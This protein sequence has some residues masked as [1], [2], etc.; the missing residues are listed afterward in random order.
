MNVKIFCGFSGGADSTA[1]L[2]LLHKL[3][4][5]ENIQLTAVHFDHGLRG[6]E[7]TS[8]AL[9]CNEF[10][11]KR[12]IK[13][14]LVSLD[15]PNN[16]KKG[17]GDEEASRRL[18]IQAWTKITDANSIIALGHNANDRIENLFL[19]LLRGSNSSG[20]TS[21]RKTS[22]IGKLLFFRPLLTIPRAKI[23]NFLVSE[24]IREWRHDSSNSKSSYRRNFI[25]NVLVSEL[26]RKIPSAE[27][28]IL[29]SVCAVENDAQYI[30]HQ[31]D[32]EYAKFANRG[33]IPLEYLQNS[34]PAILIRIL[35]LWVKNESG[36]DFIPNAAFLNRL[37]TEIAKFA[38]KGKKINSKSLTIPV[39]E[40]IKFLFNKK[41][42]FIHQKDIPDN[43][44]N[45]KSD[46]SW[47]CKKQNKIIWGKFTFR[48]SLVPKPRLQ[49]M[50]TKS[51]NYTVFYDAEN[52][53]PILKIRGWNNDDKIIPFGMSNQVKVKK[54]LENAKIPAPERKNIPVITIPSNDQIIWIPG[55][56]RANFAN[57]ASKTRGVIVLKLCL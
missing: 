11:K 16:R 8:D 19:R 28:A 42:L 13:F 33:F 50:F 32:M 51:N 35:R 45:E 37:R 14:V 55:V 2:L 17:E 18:R 53:P 9:W 15:V 56:K 5:K 1:L 26:K 29:R 57:I 31:A 43:E 54:I 20:L 25:R 27:N 49:Q 48:S 36:T 22:K 41:G 23:E 52:F 21:M 47:N 7:S 38:K 46:I 12:K 6:Q 40:D 4:K 24:G 10:C 39:S 34:H 44:H 3:A 30:E